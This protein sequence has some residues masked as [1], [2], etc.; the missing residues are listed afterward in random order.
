MKLA[1]LVQREGN[2]PVCGR[3]ERCTVCGRWARRRV[4]SVGPVGGPT[5]G[6]RGAIGDR[7]AE[8]AERRFRSGPR[9]RSRPGRRSP[10]PPRVGTPI[11]PTDQTRRRAHRPHTVRAPRPT[12][13]PDRLARPPRPTAPPRSIPDM[14]T[15][16]DPQHFLQR[17]GYA[18]IDSGFT[19]VHRI[20]EEFDNV[21]AESK[22]I[23]DPKDPKR[24]FSLGEFSALNFPSAFHHTWLR[25]MREALLAAVL[26]NDVLDTKGGFKVEVPFDRMLFRRAGITTKGE[27]F[28]RDVL[29]NARPG[30]RNLGG[31]INLDDSPQHLSYCPGTHLEVGEGKGFAE[32]TSEQD[33]KKYASLLRSIEIGPMQIVLFYANGVHTVAKTDGRKDM[34]RLFFSLR[35]T[36]EDEPSHGTKATT[37]WVVDQAVPKLPSGDKAP[38][39][40]K[41]YYNF[42]CNYDK[43]EKWS[44]DTFGHLKEETGTAIYVHAVKSKDPALD[45]R[46]YW[47]VRRDFPSLRALESKGVGVRM[48]RDYDIHEHALLFPGRR[49]RLRTARGGVEKRVSYRLP[50]KK[51]WQLYK[52]SKSMAPKGASVRRPA[53]VR[54][55]NDE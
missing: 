17:N 24:V 13:S 25:Y 7:R 8:I 1:Q 51:E 40:P 29:P 12:A 19:D 11:G 28:H 50:S 52:L 16:T 20:R 3:R 46:R 2:H 32:I 48:H 5:L 14:D 30:D 34:R 15:F 35:T 22:E 38:M 47:R 36:R 27:G 9:R 18:V 37:S 42:S 33:K 10:R 26:D 55:S 53:P 23:R 39:F 45:G 49:W 4:W 54:I 21:L 43:L 31:W 41:S 6:G 44:E